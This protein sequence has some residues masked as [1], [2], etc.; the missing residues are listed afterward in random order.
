MRDILRNKFW[1]KDRIIELI[2]K[3]IN[4]LRDNRRKCEGLLLKGIHYDGRRGI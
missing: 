3:Q 2:K 4:D 1:I